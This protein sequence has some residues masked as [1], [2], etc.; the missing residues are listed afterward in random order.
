MQVRSWLVI[1]AKFGLSG[2]D[3]LVVKTGIHLNFIQWLKVFTNKC[4]QFN[5]IIDNKNQTNLC[6]FE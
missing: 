4:Q 2:V 3:I 5:A 6:A 1:I